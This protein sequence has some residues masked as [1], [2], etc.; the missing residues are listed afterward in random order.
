M[1]ELKEICEEIATYIEKEKQTENK[2]VDLLPSP[3]FATMDTFSFQTEH[4]E[5]EDG[6]QRDSMTD[7]TPFSICLQRPVHCS[8]SFSHGINYGSVSNSNPATYYVLV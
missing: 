4:C 2:V 5:I 7:N 1:L 3:S 6:L 8:H